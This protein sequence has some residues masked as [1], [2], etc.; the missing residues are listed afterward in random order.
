RIKVFTQRHSGSE[1]RRK[2]NKGLWILPFSLRPPCVSAAPW[3]AQ[4]SLFPRRQISPALDDVSA[5]RL[6]II[7]AQPFAECGHPARRIISLEHDLF[8]HLENFRLRHRQGRNKSAAAHRS[9]AVTHC[10]PLREY[11]AALINHF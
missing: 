2:S 5:N 7:H 6:D 4:L 3:L 10:A 8:V 11:R 1:T 9:R